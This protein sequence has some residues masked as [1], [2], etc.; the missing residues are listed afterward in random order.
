MKKKLTYIIILICGILNAQDSFE[1]GEKFFKN[2]DWDLAKSEFQEV[3]YAST[4]Y[5]KSQE[6]L[7][8]IAAQQKKWDQALNFY[9]YLVEED[10]DNANY[11][12]K[13]GGALG[14]KALEISKMRATFYI[15]DIKYYLKKAAQL[16]VKHIKTRWA[17]VEL[18][19]KL[20]SLLGGSSA[21][22]YNYAEQLQEINEV[23]GW[24]AKGFIAKE[25][26]NYSLAEENF[27]KALKVETSLTCYK[28]LLE[29]YLNHTKENLKAKRL[30]EEAKKNYPSTNWNSFSRKFS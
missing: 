24:L 11:N 30:L 25:E 19:I 2:K 26:G 13:Y 21:V 8:D 14:M 9:K 1:K 28:K 10:P 27:K 3:N 17:L 16:D 4:Y 7:G 15:S 29:L 12:F 5:L 23:E 22:A 6:Y 18:Y 20:P